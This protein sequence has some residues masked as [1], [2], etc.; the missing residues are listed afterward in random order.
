MKVTNLVKGAVVTLAALGM[1][2]PQ[3]QVEAATGLKGIKAVK[4]VEASVADISLANGALIGRVVDHTGA[5]MASKEVV[6]RQ[7]K[8]EVAKVQTDKSG[9]FAVSN[10]KGGLYE[11]TAGTSTG[12]FRV[13]TESAAPSSAAEQA[14]LI[15][16]ENGVRGGS[17]TFGGGG[18]GFGGIMG[19]GTLV[20]TAAVIASV[21][22]SGIALGKINDLQDDV[23][24]IPKSP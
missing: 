13:W 20:L 16:G 5:A 4:T 24:N 1:V 11:V 9:T 19:D 18:G 17:G 7:G 8:N 14:L 10:L 2:M 22:I 6:V 21:I 12:T 23:D 15:V 3:G